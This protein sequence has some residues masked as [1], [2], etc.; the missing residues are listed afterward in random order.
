MAALRKTFTTALVGLSAT[1]AIAGCSSSDPDGPDARRTGAS[2]SRTSNP[3]GTSQPESPAP[4]GD[5]SPSSSASRGAPYTDGGYTVNGEYGT[6]GSSI[7]V[8]LTLEG[9][10]ITAVEV[11]P[12]ATDDTS[13]ALQT[14]F[15]EAVP[16]LVVGRDIDDV[17][18]DRVAGNSNTPQGFN[19]A[20]EE[21]KDLAGR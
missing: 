18:L 9:G 5:S 12:H 7:G 17:Q 3:P 16:R 1:A 19:D 6:R 2:S 10:E 20:L 21:I 15:A 13:R 8:E 11:T 4:S 14:R